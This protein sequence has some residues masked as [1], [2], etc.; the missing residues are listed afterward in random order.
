MSVGEI[1][2]AVELLCVLSP[3][4][5]VVGLSFQLCSIPMALGS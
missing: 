3:E 2:K 4:M 5:S 1:L